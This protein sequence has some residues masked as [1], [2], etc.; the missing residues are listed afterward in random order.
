MRLADGV[1]VG[2]EA[3]VRW[4]PPTR[5]LLSPAQLLP[6]AEQAGLLRPL[7][8]TVL[9]LA[10]TAVARWWRQRRVPVSVNLS[11]ANVT[12]LDLPSKVE[13]ALRRHG[14]PAAA[15][16]LALVEDTLMPDPDRGR[17]ALGDRES[18]M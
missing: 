2:A 7:T 10:L 17:R 6:A 11:A 16:T 15:L 3:L 8:D 5:G 4:Q 9:D 14:L 1:V 12:D 18:V 13:S